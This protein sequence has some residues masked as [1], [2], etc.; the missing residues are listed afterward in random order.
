M[1][2]FYDENLFP[3]FF[4]LQQFFLLDLSL[5]YMILWAVFICRFF[6]IIYRNIVTK[7]IDCQSLLHQSIVIYFVFFSNN[8]HIL[9]VVIDE[10][11]PLLV[12]Q[13]LYRYI[14]MEYLLSEF[15]VFV[16]HQLFRVL[17]DRL[18][19]ACGNIW[20]IPLCEKAITQF[21]IA[22]SLFHIN[23][24]FIQLIVLFGSGF[25]FRL[26]VV[27]MVIFF[28]IQH[29]IVSVKLIYKVIYF[30]I[31]VEPNHSEIF[32]LMIE[33]P[34]EVI[35]ALLNTEEFLLEDFPIIMVEFSGLLTVN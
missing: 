26:A 5:L 8:S 11:W 15:L 1:L 14:V 21:L 2:S 10:L 35:M 27:A 17:R 7:H 31:R 18:G 28:F 4:I 32:I 30:L 23:I 24:V 25:K 22:W 29:A 9:I 16:G 20:I 6:P 13:S 19:T 3:E 12:D 33:D 34:Y